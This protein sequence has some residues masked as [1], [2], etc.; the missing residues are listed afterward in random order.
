[1]EKEYLVLNLFRFSAELTSAWF[2]HRI[3]IR[4]WTTVKIAA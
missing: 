1:M 3:I 2:F 4:A